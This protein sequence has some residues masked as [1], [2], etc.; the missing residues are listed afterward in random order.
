MPAL[1]LQ[2]ESPKAAP[3]LLARG[4]PEVATGQPRQK[5]AERVVVVIYGLR[6]SCVAAQAQHLGRR[7]GVPV[8]TMDGLIEVRGGLERGGVV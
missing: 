4:T 8:V 3:E 5:A 6:M 1:A 2:G 7:Y